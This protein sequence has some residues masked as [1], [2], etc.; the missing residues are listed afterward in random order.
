MTLDDGREIADEIAVADAHPLGARPLAPAAT[1]SAKF[2]SLADGI[3]AAAE[4]DRFLGSGR[5][6]ARA[7]GRPSLHGSASPS[8]PTHLA[9]GTATGTA[10][11][12]DADRSHARYRR[13]WHVEMH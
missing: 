13:P 1:M 2:R 5:A 7:E 9:G 6:A 10:V 4:Q 11:V 8:I 3:V 12:F